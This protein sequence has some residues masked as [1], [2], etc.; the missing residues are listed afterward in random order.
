MKIIQMFYFLE[1]GQYD[2]TRFF[3]KYAYS[4]ELGLTDVLASLFFLLLIIILKSISI[5][6][7][8]KSDLTQA[9]FS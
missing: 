3:R 5:V 4:F 7:V 8:L 2:F 1:F 6:V 9:E